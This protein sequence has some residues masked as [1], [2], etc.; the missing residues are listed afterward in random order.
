MDDGYVKRKDMLASPLGLFSHSP[1]KRSA[2][3]HCRVRQ[4]FL[5]DEVN[6]YQDKLLEK[7]SVPTQPPCPPMPLT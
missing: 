3:F 6:V 4:L 2:L 7:R 1:Q 5:A